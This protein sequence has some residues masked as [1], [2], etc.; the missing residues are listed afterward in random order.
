MQAAY[1]FTDNV[2]IMGGYS[3]LNQKES[4]QNFTRK[5]KY[6]EL[7]LGYFKS[8]R[9]YRFE[10]F[11][12]YGLG[13][14][15]SLA[16]YY[17]Y[18]SNFGVTD[19]VATGKY[20]RI[21][22]QPTIASNNRKFNLAFTPRI[23]VVDFKEFTS[24]GPPLPAPQ[25]APVTKKPDEKPYLFL[26]PAL[27]GKFPLVGNLVGVFQLGLAVPASSDAYFDVVPLQT[28]IGIQLHVGGKLRTRVY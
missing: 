23:S 28:S 20:S 22:F 9:S 13:E 26:E 2:A 12:G 8:D 19:I 3:M 11:V 27:T 6:G 25:S 24:T 1:S 14:G 18:A 10:L 5:N 7:G 16:N 4:A 21:F 15:T 17:F